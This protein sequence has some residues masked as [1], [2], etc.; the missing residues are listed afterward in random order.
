MSIPKN[1]HYVSKCHQKEF[2]NSET[3]EIYVYDKLLD[4]LYSKKSTKNLFSENLLNTIKTDSQFD[5]I[6]LET[7]LKILFEDKFH[8]HLVII[9]NFLTSQDDTDKAYESLCW[10]TLLGIVGE[11]R[12]PKFKKEIDILMLDL[13]AEIFERATGI[14]KEKLMTRFKSELKT[15]YSNTIGYINVALKILGKMEPLDFLIY[16]I[17][18][19]DSFILPDTS[20]FQIRG[21]LKTHI[22]PSINEIIQIGIPLSD[23]LLIIATP[24]IFETNLHGIQFIR[25][26]NSNEVLKLN[27]FLFEFAKKAVVCKNKKNL[28]QTIE[29]IKN[30]YP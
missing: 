21:Q 19:E 17:E 25:Q 7:E 28:E 24:K 11:M 30:S 5:N 18:S 20:C 8:Q 4:N 6:T 26:N 16:S 22:N 27:K 1:H 3:K 13:K 2:F 14:S 29:R 12:H 9:N 23:K 15:P 10:L